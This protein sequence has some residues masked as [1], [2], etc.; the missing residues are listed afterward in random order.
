MMRAERI[1]KSLEGAL[2]DVEGAGKR[3]GAIAVEGLKSRVRV[4]V[5]V[6]VKVRVR[7]RVKVRVKG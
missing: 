4:K 5:R 7:V 6:K 2:G 1:E 3:K